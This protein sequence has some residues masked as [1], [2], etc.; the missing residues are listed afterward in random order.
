MGSTPPLAAGHDNGG[1]PCQKKPEVNRTIRYSALPEN[2][3]TPSRLSQGSAVGGMG[4]WRIFAMRGVA[5][6][7]NL[8]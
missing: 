3:H 2:S 5:A 4:A 7:L 1:P 6:L 8:L